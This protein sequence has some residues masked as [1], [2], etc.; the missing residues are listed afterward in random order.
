[1]D[2]GRTMAGRVAIAAWMAVLG[3]ALVV[4]IALVIPSLPDVARYM[5]IRQM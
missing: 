2:G 3:A 5:R 4:L 1:M